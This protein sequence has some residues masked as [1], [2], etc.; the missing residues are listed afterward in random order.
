M[1]AR[2][3]LA[4]SWVASQSHLCP[5]CARRG[6]RREGGALPRKEGKRP[7]FYTGCLVCGMVWGFLLPWAD[8][9][10]YFEEV[11]NR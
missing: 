7:C 11:N 9:V 3:D 5:Y 8:T 1:K 4:N 6:G 2:K 10:G